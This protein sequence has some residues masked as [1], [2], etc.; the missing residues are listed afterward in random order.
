MA[1]AVIDRICSPIR[2]FYIKVHVTVTW[3]FLLVESFEQRVHSL[4]SEGFRQYG[5]F[6]ARHPYSL[7]V[8]SIAIFLITSYPLTE[9]GFTEYPPLE[10]SESSFEL[11]PIPTW[12]C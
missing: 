6:A 8:F 9:I 1:W 3:L 7:L 12:V 10:F 4:I 5:F 2:N 11:S